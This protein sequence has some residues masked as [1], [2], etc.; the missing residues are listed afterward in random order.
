[1]IDTLKRWVPLCHDAFEQY[2]LGAVLLSAK[3]VEAVQ[4]MLKGEAVTAETVGLSKREW[5][6]LMAALGRPA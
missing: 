4:R 1:M 2:R 5:T 6:E 3:A